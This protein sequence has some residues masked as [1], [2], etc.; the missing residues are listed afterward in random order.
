[1]DII[2]VEVFENRP[3]MAAN[4]QARYLNIFWPNGDALL[5]RFN[6]PCDYHGIVRMGAAQAFE[7]SP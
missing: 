1:M 3:C 7:G 2:S 5:I 6:Y 4:I